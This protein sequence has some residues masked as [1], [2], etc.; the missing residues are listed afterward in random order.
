MHEMGATRKKPQVEARIELLREGRAAGGLAPVLLTVEKKH[1]HRA[2]GEPLPGR[3]AALVGLGAARALA[4][5]ERLE[6]LADAHAMTQLQHFGGD[7]AAVVEVVLKKRARFRQGGLIG[8]AVVAFAGALL[9]RSVIRRRGDDD[10][11]FD[12][13]AVAETVKTQTWQYVMRV[14]PYDDDATAD[15]QFAN[16]VRTTLHER[17]AVGEFEAVTTGH[18]QITA[19]MRQLRTLPLDARIELYV[20][21][22][23][24]DQVG[25]YGQ[26]AAH[27]RRAA[28]RWSIAALVTESLALISALV[29]IF[30]DTIA[31]L[32]FVGVL[33]SAAAAFTAW[34]ELGRNG[35]VARAY[36]L[37]N[38]ELLAIES[39]CQAAQTEADLIAL[40]SDGESAISREHTMWVAKR[41]NPV[42]STGS[43]SAT[44]GR[45]AREG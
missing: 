26:K 11:W 23:L 21:G 39:L 22:R 8:C 25:W 3:R 16:D 35:E 42:E 28:D 12:G 44:A 7:E 1:R 10:R 43:S 20:R 36:G 32:G 29:A 6:V 24:G 41:A 2:P 34:N 4:S 45:P 30:S 38:Q 15:R 18:G 40:V 5:G 13:R 19:Q 31:Q 33:A 9:A 14:P 17:P 27:H 37:A